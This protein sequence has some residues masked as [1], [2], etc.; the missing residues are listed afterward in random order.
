M[1][2][3]AIQQEDDEL[4]KDAVE[5]LIERTEPGTPGHALAMALYEDEFGDSEVES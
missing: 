1:S 2:V 4:D 5:T 3:D